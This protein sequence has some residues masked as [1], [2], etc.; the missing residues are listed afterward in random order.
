MAQFTD[1][2]TSGSLSEEWLGDRS[3]FVINSQNQLQLMAPAAGASYLY[4]S[5]IYPDSFSMSFNLRMTFPPSN[6][7]LCRIYFLYDNPE[8]AQ[9]KGYY[10]NFGEN[11]NDDAIRVFR[12]SGNQAT[13]IAAGKLG[14]IASE[15]VTV[16]FRLD[17]TDNGMSVI[18]TDYTGGEVLLADIEYFDDTYISG[19]EYY[20]GMYF[21]YSATRTDRYFFDFISL[22]EYVPDLEGPI[23]SNVIAETRD[24]VRLVFNEVLDDTSAENPELYSINRGV[25]APVFVEILRPNE[26]TLTFDN[27]LDARDF[28][29][30]SING[31]QDLFGN[32]S[33]IT[34]SFLLPSTPG[35][36][37][38]ILSE[39]LADPVSGGEDFIELYNKSQNYLELSGLTIRN[40]ARNDQRVLSRSHIMP[41]GQYLAI[42]RNIQALLDI[43]DPPANANLLQNDLPGLNIADGNV[44]IYAPGNLISALDS[45][46]YKNAMHNRFI[47]NTK[48]VSLERIDFNLPANSPNN[49]QS[50][51]SRVNF[52][53]PGY[54]NS[55][56]APGLGVGMLFEIVKK[57]FSPRSGPESVM[58]A[59][60]ELPKP[61]FICNLFVH[62]SNGQ[63]I[64][65]L[66]RNELMST[67]GIITW[68][69]SNENGMIER[70][71]I[72]IISGDFFHAD[73]DI[74]RVKEVCVL[75]ENLD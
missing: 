41:P 43:Y 59:R 70:M 32:S 49:W 17:Y 65:R 56:S 67:E 69:G 3:N 10:L 20:F 31:I 60:Y 12:F 37:E 62:D 27:E 19:K 21:L 26:V 34:R 53:T 29:E 11:G 73:G 57:T 51:S 63:L 15:P 42:S 72:Y 8:L 18:Y 52:G 45:F 33:F 28:Y 48:G 5:A 16:N 9:A 75:A 36:G 25:G 39:M 47:N 2:F 30:I 6:A 38:L 1:D 4:R 61:G 58:V 71:G 54:E 35:V 74:I 66:L 46:D 64:K 24:R 40:N 23:L 50:A 14:A 22:D 68:D 13:Q 7:N 55:N 44:S